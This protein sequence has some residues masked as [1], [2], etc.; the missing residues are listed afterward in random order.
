MSED[1]KIQLNVPSCSDKLIW[2]IWLSSNDLPALTVADDL[3]L[4]SYL[5]KEPASSLSIARNF[6]LSFRGTE[7]LLGVLTSL[8][9]L[10][11][12]NGKFC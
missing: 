4:F 6:F 3:G 12:Q 1:K 2:D 11:Q 8:R 10:V 9:F 7:A 5:E